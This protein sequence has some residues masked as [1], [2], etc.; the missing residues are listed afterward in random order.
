MPILKTRDK[1]Q[2]T[3]VENRLRFYE[4]LQKLQATEY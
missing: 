1:N 2:K 4:Y 3:D